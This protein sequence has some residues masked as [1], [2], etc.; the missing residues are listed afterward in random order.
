MPTGYTSGIVDGTTKTFQDYAKL[1]VRAFGAAIH[2]RDD[3]LKEEWRPAEPSS[4][5]LENIKSSEKEL[6]KIKT[7]SVE[8]IRERRILSLKESIKYDKKRI[9]E[10]KEVG[11][12]YKSIL[13][14]VEKYEPP[15]DDHH[16]FKKFMKEQIEMC[17]KSD[18]D[19]SYTEKDVAKCTND[20]EKLESDDYVKAVEKYRK[21]EIKRIE[22]NIAYYNKNYA[23]DVDRCNS[24]NEW[25]KQVF[26]SIY[27]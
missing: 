5:Y 16:E 1:C 10:L 11:E 12:R 6:E 23:E 22:S 25:V 18:S 26:D 7:E 24:R 17:I 2:M 8:S 13:E 9:V 27:K 21:E 20:L 19:T 3:G 15:T 4:Y 14:D